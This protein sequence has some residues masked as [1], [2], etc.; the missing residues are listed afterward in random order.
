M[1]KIDSHPGS[2]VPSLSTPLHRSRF[3][4]SSNE[5]ETPSLNQCNRIERQFT[6]LVK[7]H[8]CPGRQE[9]TGAYLGLIDRPVRSLLRAEG[10]EKLGEGDY[11]YRSRPY[12]IG[13]WQIAPVIHIHAW[14]A[15]GD[16]TICCQ[17]SSPEIPSNTSA[18]L[19]P[20]PYKYG[21]EASLRGLEVGV[22]VRGMLWLQSSLLSWAW[23]QALSQLV[24]AELE[25]R[26]QQRLGRGLTRDFERWYRDIYP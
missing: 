11:L 4:Q 1:T 12:R 15:Q 6:L 23:S 16:L 21:L 18:I 14:T 25:R 10:T 3:W 2:K 24:M 9:V 17:A 7:L 20:V 13:P 5:S 8:P 26:L 22:E 19:N